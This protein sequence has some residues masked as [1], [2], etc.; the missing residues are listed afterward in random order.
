DSALRPD[1]SGRRGGG[2][3]VPPLH[4]RRGLA[5]RLGAGRGGPRAGPADRGGH[6]PE[7]APALPR[8]AARSD[9]GQRLVDPAQDPRREPVRPQQPVRA[10]GEHRARND[11]RGG[12]RPGP[13]ALRSPRRRLPAPGAGRRAGRRGRGV[14]TAAGRG[15]PHGGGRP[16]LPAPRL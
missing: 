9:A 12:I 1:G 4:P 8:R 10:P 13:P 2:A 16:A 14:R 7:P 15:P 6:H 5:A 3:A 11:V